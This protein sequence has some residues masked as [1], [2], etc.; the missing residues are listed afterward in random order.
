MRYRSHVL[1]SLL[2]GFVLRR[3]HEILK[4]TLPLKYE[5]VLFLR[6]TQVQAIL[7]EYSRTAMT[8]QMRGTSLTAGP[9]KAFA[10]F[11]K[12]HIPL[13]LTT[14][15]TVSQ[16]LMFD[17]TY[18]SDASPRI[19]NLHIPGS[20][21]ECSRHVNILGVEHVQCTMQI[22][23]HPDIYYQTAMAQNSKQVS[24]VSYSTFVNV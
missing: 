8:K 9:F 14:V 2:E 1:H 21:I 16:W 23:N 11:S 13:C 17:I 20:L 19:C 24:L 22:W 7:Y 10:V 15:C 5:H 4:A 6:P 3:G 18:S 12:V